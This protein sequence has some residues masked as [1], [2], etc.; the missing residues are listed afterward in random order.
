MGKVFQ[1][2]NIDKE[3][4]FATM[5]TIIEKMV[6]S[7]LQKIDQNSTNT[8]QQ[9]EIFTRQEAADFLKINVRSLDTRLSEGKIKYSKDQRFVAIKKSELIKYLDNY[10][11]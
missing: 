7:H 1:V 9:E 4:F 2:E 6:K 5:E 10:E 3:E 11:Q 8:S